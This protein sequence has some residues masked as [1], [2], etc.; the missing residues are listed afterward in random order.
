MKRNIF[1]YLLL[2]PALLFLFISCRNEDELI[3]N[4]KVEIKEVGHHGHH[5]SHAG[6]TI[7]AGDELHLAAEIIAP[8]KIDFL[9]V[10]IYSKTTPTKSIV[11]K[12]FPSYKGQINAHFH[13]HIDIPKDTTPGDYVVSISVASPKSFPKV[14]EAPLK[15]EAAEK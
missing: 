8:N 6:N 2:L 5:G 1:K 4:I 9:N 11:R 3:D 15:I 13:E 14:A 12:S 7:H 10:D